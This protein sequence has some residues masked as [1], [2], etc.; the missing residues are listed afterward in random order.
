MSPFGMEPQ[1]RGDPQSPEEK[2]LPPDSALMASLRFN[3][4]FHNDAPRMS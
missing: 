3:L 2:S 1:G 4:F